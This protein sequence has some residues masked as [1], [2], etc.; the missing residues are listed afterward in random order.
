M[1]NDKALAERVRDEA[2][3]RAADLASMAFTT[4]PPATLVN[5]VEA[6]RLARAVLELLAERAGAIG[7][8]ISERSRQITSGGR[9]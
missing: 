4:A 6:E 2:D 5:N 3:R 1:D 8:I 7:D 9:C